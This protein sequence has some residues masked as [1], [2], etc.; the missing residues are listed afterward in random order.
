MAILADFMERKWRELDARLPPGPK[1]RDRVFRMFAAASNEYLKA[2]A[3]PTPVKDLGA[4]WQRQS[5]HCRAMK[6]EQACT[7]LRRGTF[8][9][10]AMI[11]DLQKQWRDLQYYADFYEGATFHRREFVFNLLLIWVA[12]GGNWV[13]RNKLGKPSGPADRLPDVRL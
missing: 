7:W 4:K 12:C 5:K 9:I 13:S 6:P 1:G 8:Q 3:N 10:T 2:M 11:D